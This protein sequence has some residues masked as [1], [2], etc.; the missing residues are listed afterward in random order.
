MTSV[1][2]DPLGPLLDALKRTGRAI[3]SDTVRAAYDFAVKAHGTQVRLSGEPYV[4]HC[5]AVATILADLLGPGADETLV[6]AA[7]LHDVVEDTE[8]SLKDVERA[9]GREV[10][11][12]VDGVSKISGL[13]FDRPERE[14][15]ENFRKMLFS[16]ARDLRVILIKLADRLHNMR[17][18]QALEAPRAD[19]IARETREIYA[20]LAHRLGIARIKWELEDLSL[21]Y[22]DPQ[23]YQEIRQKVAL[24]REERE[25][26]VAAVMQPVRERLLSLGIKADVVGR[27]KHLDSI[28][29]KM[30]AQGRLFEE[31][32]DL[33]GVRVLT[34]DNAD[35]YRVLG[36]VHDLFTPVHG[37]FK[38][39]IATP[40]T[41]MY[42]SLHTTVVAPGG[43]MVEFQ[44]RTQEMHLVAEL[45]V[46]AHYRYKEG[47]HRSDSEVLG[48]LAP[49]LR[50]LDWQSNAGD[51]DEFMEF[52]KTS[53]YQDEVFVFTPRGDLRRL[54]RGSTP[55]DFAFQIHTEVGHHCVGAKVNGR[56]V[57]LRYE[58]RS[59]DSVQIIT[60]PAGKPNRDWLKVV[61]ST[62]ARTKIRHWL[63]ISE[64]ADSVALGR[65]MIERELRRRRLAPP[66][67]VSIEDL[68][69][70]MG[71]EDLP[72]L[73][74]AVGSGTVSV[75]H[76]LTRWFPGGIGPVQRI[77]EASLET[78]RAITGRPGRGVRIQ[79]VDNLMVSYAKCCQPVPGD[80]VVGIVTR[81]RGVTVHRT[82]CPNTFD[83]RV[84]PERRVMVDWG[85]AADG[86]FSVKLSIYGVD[87]KSLLADIAKAIATTNTNIRT[88]GI[89]ASDRNARGAFVVEVRDLA[90]LRLVMKA[91]EQVDGVEGVEREQVFGKP[92]GGAAGLAS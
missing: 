26:L 50:N 92:R 29:R 3:N 31:I 77:K 5:L 58:L 85:E 30:K 45:G 71:Y 65:E 6:Q 87:R 66:P 83:G 55:I 69:R 57:P 70:A 63:K 60:S 18:L 32:F 48:K 40:K 2:A 59:G 13:H 68:A 8:V 54:P 74:A 51:P 24:K 44:I 52:L 89:K 36:V 61:R 15:A 49:M 7:M 82:D 67:S 90:H 35:C 23:A 19:R 53:L 79:G 11:A 14:Q 73:H 75:A 21:K 56:I 28:Y 91:V 16:M 17:T 81:G 78:F 80:P 22:L 27:P 72:G 42:Q 34:Q 46:A 39:Y 76:V 9:F 33:L 88:A 64:Q 12:L 4:T 20:P 43:L 62:A 1:P 37:R 25:G 10:A 47:G 38:D 84:A 41:N 86:S